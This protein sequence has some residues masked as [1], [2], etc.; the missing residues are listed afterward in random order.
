MKRML[1]SFASGNENA[2]P[3]A[4]LVKA[5]RGPDSSSPGRGLD[6]L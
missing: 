6:K 1:V 4:K 3:R 2:V 5:I